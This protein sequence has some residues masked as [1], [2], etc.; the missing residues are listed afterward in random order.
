MRSAR[1]QPLFQTAVIPP[2]KGEFRR[3]WVWLRG[4]W[5][6]LGRAQRFEGAGG[7]LAARQQQKPAHSG[8]WRATVQLSRQPPRS[9]RLLK[10]L[11]HWTPS[12]FRTRRKAWHPIHAA[13]RHFERHIGKRLSRPLAGKDELAVDFRREL[14][15]DFHLELTPA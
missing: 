4:F 2:G 12:K 5:A 11:R 7:A 14:T 8:T 1:F 13:K 3:Q 10:K 9:T 15:R 6:A